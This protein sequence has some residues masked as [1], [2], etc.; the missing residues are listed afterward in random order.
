MIFH[1]Q[2]TGFSPQKY[3]VSVY[4]YKYFIENMG[5]NLMRL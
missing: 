5:L 2:K 4:K 3:E 1:F